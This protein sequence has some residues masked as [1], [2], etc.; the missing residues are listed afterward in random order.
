MPKASGDVSL[1]CGHGVGYVEE[2]VGRE[3]QSTVRRGGPWHRRGVARQSTEATNVSAPATRRAAAETD[4]VRQHAS[5]DE[6]ATAETNKSTPSTAMR[7]REHRDSTTST[8]CDESMEA[9]NVSAPARRRAAAKANT[10]HRHAGID[11]G[12]NTEVV[13]PAPTAARART[14]VQ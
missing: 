6:G 4:I 12:K 14:L 7:W 2:V 10:V 11:E 13:M 1:D 8:D 9:A 3:T 5:I